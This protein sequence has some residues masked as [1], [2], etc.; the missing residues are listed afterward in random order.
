MMRIAG[1]VAGLGGTVLLVALA[2][3]A[4]KG[5]DESATASI[6]A[7]PTQPP[8]AR[9]DP[10]RTT[11]DARP[12]PVAKARPVGA[13]VVVPPAV[14]PTKL[15]RVAPREP[16]GN[17]ALAM[18]PKPGVPE[19]TLLHRPVATA[20]GRLEAQGHSV[21]LAGITP[22]DPD[23]TC[24]ATDGMSW[25]C[26]MV[27]RT[28]FRNFLRGRAVTCTVADPPSAE[29]V[30]TRCSLGEQDVARWLVEN[31]FVIAMPGGPYSDAGEKAKR[32][33][34]GIF[35]PGSR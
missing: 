28:A 19:K 7:P 24:V 5:A 9:A 10:V 12:A 33:R 8:A 6:A 34:R 16:L 35:G 21:A 27:A 4:L 20:A 11:S 25:P 3:N 29:T 17:L 13:S 31:G 18:P 22:V 23:E 14:D 15:E 30:I 2:G 1:I 32:D 26:G